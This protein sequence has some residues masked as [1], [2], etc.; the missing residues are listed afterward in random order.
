[1]TVVVG[2]AMGI[3][4]SLPPC[5]WEILK[6]ETAGRPPTVTMVL[7]ELLTVNPPLPFAL[8]VLTP[9]PDMDAVSGTRTS[10]RIPG[11]KKLPTGRLPEPVKETVVSHVLL[12]AG[13]ARMAGARLNINRA[14]AVA[15]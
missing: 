11:E 5:G 3:P 9:V 13:W 8:A 6:G 15:K 14:V 7:K 4:G 12:S 10:S 1:M 2:A